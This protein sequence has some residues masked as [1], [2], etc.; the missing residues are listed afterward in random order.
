MHRS[1]EELKQDN[2]GI[3]ALICFFPA[4]PSFLLLLSEADRLRNDQYST[5][6]EIKPLMFY[7]GI[8]ALSMFGLLAG[9]R[10]Y[11]AG[12]AKIKAETAKL[13]EK[14]RLFRAAEAAKIEEKARPIRAAE[15]AEAAKIKADTATI[16]ALEEAEKIRADAATIR[17]AE[18]IRADAAIVRAAEEAAKKCSKNK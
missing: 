11:Y 3:L 2:W 15:A 6:V 8:F 1:R 13:K 4:V 14:A 9:C 18:K 17:A 5:S 12:T 10:N 16:R 7:L